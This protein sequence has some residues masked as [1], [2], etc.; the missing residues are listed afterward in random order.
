MPKASPKDTSVAPNLP[1][2]ENE[3]QALDVLR[4]S[5]VTADGLCDALGWGFLESVETL[6]SLVNKGYATEGAGGIYVI[7]K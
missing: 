1:L 2:D 5:S 7:Y 4:L 3:K 6:A